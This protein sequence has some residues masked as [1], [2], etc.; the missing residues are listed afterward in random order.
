MQEL[1]MIGKRQV[2][3]HFVEREKPNVVALPPVDPILPSSA[4]KDYAIS[5]HARG[6][7]AEY[8][9]GDRFGRSDSA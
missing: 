6:F 4:W 3:F 7:S 1:K 9:L 5:E 2:D 8:G